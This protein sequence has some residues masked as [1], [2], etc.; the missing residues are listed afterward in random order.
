M[1]T[2]YKVNSDKR[3]SAFIRIADATF[4]NERRHVF[5]QCNHVYPRALAT[6]ETP[7]VDIVNGKSKCI[8][9]FYL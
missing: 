5:S 9:L 8:A 1:S 7:L 2:T 4:L 3:Q 6:T